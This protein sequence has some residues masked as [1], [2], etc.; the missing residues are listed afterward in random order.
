MKRNRGIRIIRESIAIIE[1]IVVSFIAWCP[2]PFSKNSCPGRTPSPVSSS[3][4]PR[5]TAGIKSM[6]VCVIAIAVIKINMTVTGKEVKKINVR[7][8]VAIRFIWTLG[9]S[10]VIVPAKIPKIN[11]SINSI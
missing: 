9:I 1:P 11:A 4:A 10:P 8:I 2:W 7:R 5:N 6:N 3:G